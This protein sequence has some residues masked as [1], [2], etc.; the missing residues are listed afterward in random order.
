MELLSQVATLYGLISLKT[1]AIAFLVSLLLVHTAHWHGHLSMDHAGGVQKFH[2]EPTPR[3]GGIG[4]FLGLLLAWFLLEPGPVRLL[5]GVILLAGVP[6]LVFGLAEDVTK[7][8][9]VLPRLLATMVSGLLAC[10]LSGVALSRLDVPLLDLC[11]G[12]CG[13]CGEHH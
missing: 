3:V 9:G 13:Q 5:L 11:R 12:G 10:L 1:T 7:R 2:V 6:A 4:I 8:V